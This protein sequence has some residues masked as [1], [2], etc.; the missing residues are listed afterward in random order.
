MTKKSNSKH[1]GGM[2]RVAQEVIVRTGKELHLPDH[3]VDRLIQPEM[4]YEMTLPMK[5]SDGSYEVVKAFRVQHNSVLGPFKGGIRFHHEVS[6]DEVQAL[7]TLMTIKCSLAGL[8]YGGAKG[9][10]CVD[11]KELCDIQLEQISRDYV[12]RIAR[13]IGQDIDIPAPD[14]NTN[15]RIIGWML[16]EYEKI[17]GHKAP[18][19]FTGKALHQGGS[20]GR[21]EA[22]G[23]G[24]VIVL[25]ELIAAIHKMEF[26]H[27]DSGFV[28]A[29]LCQRVQTHMTENQER[30]LTLAVQGFGNVGYHFA[31]IAQQQGYH[32]VGLSDSKGGIIS[33]KN[34][35]HGHYD[36]LNPLLLKW[37]K[38]QEGSITHCCCVGDVCDVDTC[39]TISSEDILT[40]PVDIIVPSALGGVIGSHNMKDIKASIIIEM[41]NGP[42][43]DEAYVY[44][45]EKGV[46]II[47]DVLANVGGVVASYLEWVQSKQ[48]YWWLEN[49]V[50]AKME[51][52]LVSAFERTWVRATEKRISVRDAAF[53][54][55]I[56][57]IAEHLV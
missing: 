12:A 55:A 4:V 43:T 40:L 34:S 46:I 3:V 56:E 37:C 16:D 51:H 36:V 28:P 52:I 19:T 53:E 41:A 23:Y 24:G 1:G 39:V 5:H 48:G 7:A 30:R 8:P 57:R 18:A 49:E 14:V 38:K 32:V 44:L 42:I 21:E 27:N 25:N 17:V 33:H 10:V 31:H 9:G 29:S 47:P 15:A 35:Y 6:R 22:T 20:R 13:G 11:P 45:S 26:T 50:N 54:V 2:L